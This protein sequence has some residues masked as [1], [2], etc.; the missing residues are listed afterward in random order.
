MPD[1]S[2]VDHVSLYVVVE[3][4]RNHSGMP[5]LG[6]REGSGDKPIEHLHVTS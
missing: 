3:N 1:N 4:L 5:K 6:P 2:K